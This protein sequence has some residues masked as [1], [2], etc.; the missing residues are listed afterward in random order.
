MRSK[1]AAARQEA[2]AKVIAA[3]EPPLGLFRRLNV[4]MIL[5]RY[6]DP[7]LSQIFRMNRDWVKKTYLSKKK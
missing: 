2:L 5:F 6:R 1:S 7:N 4:L 3:G